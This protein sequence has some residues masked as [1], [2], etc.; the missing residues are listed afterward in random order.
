MKILVATTWFPTPGS[1]ATGS[2]V[3]KDV[4][5]LA[6]NNDV[7]V[8]HLVAPQ[9]A[10]GAPEQEDRGGV[11]VTRV[12]MD[13][14]PWASTSAARA[15]IEELSSDADVLH[16]MAFSTLLPLRR[17]AR[18]QLPW[19][20]T[21]HWHGVTTRADLPLVMRLGVPLL[22]PA[23]RRP[24]VVTAVSRMATAPIRELRGD[25]PTLVVPCIA[26]TPATVPP[27]HQRAGTTAEGAPLRLVSVGAMVPGK[28]PVL[29]V[30]TLAELRRVGTNASLTWV[31]DGPLRAQAESEA[32]RL[33]VAEHV[34]IT[35]QVPSE[36]VFAELARADVFVLPTR[37]ETFGVAIAEALAHGRPVVVGSEG[38]QREYVRD[39]V[40][41]FVTG[42][43]PK[44]WAEA[45]VRT[46][47]ETAHV[48]AAQIAAS[49]GRAF[50]PQAVVAGYEKAYRDAIV[51]AA[52]GAGI[53]RGRRGQTT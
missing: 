9:L 16:T 43:D 17:G 36:T 42:R 22:L 7:R 32:A 33:G 12:V 27:R 20:H 18:P 5:A 39:E 26:Q 37:S 34:R 44:D 29:M 6:E 24:D 15:A 4:A 19:V 45:I 50:S 35:G 1:P 41:T 48:P 28:D 25:L 53:V 31:G 8:L 40:G 11:P 52:C 46:D 13:P 14:R 51:G 49:I 21:E 47:A 30:A 3:A 23:L 2:F 38:A 10:Q